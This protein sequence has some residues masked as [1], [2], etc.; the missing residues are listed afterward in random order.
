MRRTQAILGLIAA[1]ILFL[2]SGAHTFLGWKAL[3]GQLL[4]A[5]AP[6]DLINGLRIGWYFGG[7][8]MVAFALI[9]VRCS[10]RRVK[11]D[12]AA[13]FELLVMGLTYALFGLWAWTVGDRNPFFIGV[14][15]VPGVLLL[16]AG[17]PL[18]G[19]R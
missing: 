19:V 18:K 17:A 16:L 5:K 1:L 14:F 3:G 7:A 8:V 13:S 2:S 6:A 12:G 9:A 15:V 11:D 4:A 10:L